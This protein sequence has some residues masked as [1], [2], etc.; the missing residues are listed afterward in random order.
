MGSDGLLSTMSRTRTCRDTALR[1]NRS[2]KRTCLGLSFFAMIA[3]A[4]APAFA[5]R[6]HGGPP[7]GAGAGAGHGSMENGNG[8][9]SSHGSS[10]ASASSPS[11]VLEHNTKLDSTLTSKLQSKGLLPAGTDLKTACAGFKNL[12]QCV[13]AI[14]VSHNLKI[15]FACLQADMTGTAPAANAG[16]ASGTGSSKMSLGKAIQTLSPDIADAKSEAKKGTKE[17]GADIKESESETA[18]S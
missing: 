11:S 9:A 2:M 10:A 5:Q 18:S 6:G 1:R 3:L 17:A 8:A 13:A 14:H 16:C 15:P 7:A 12:G 4:G